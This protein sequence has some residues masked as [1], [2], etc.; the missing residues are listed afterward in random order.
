[1]R[2]V[3]DDGEEALSCLARGHVHARDT[4]TAFVSKPSESIKVE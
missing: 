3:R 1:M 2:G 4:E